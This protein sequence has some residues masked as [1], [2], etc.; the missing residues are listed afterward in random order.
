MRGPYAGE[1]MRASRE[2]R[3]SH[4]CEQLAYC[5]VKERATEKG[6]IL[7]NQLRTVGSS[8]WKPQW[9]PRKPGALLMVDLINAVC[10]E[11]ASSR[12]TLMRCV[13]SSMIGWERVAM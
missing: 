2:E 7:T 10:R 9:R 1:A 13:H 4:S 5:I 6:D 11:I 3:E 8:S 12:G